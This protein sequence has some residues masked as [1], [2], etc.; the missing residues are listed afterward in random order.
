MYSNLSRREKGKITEF[1]VISRLIKK[2]LDLYVPVIDVGIDCILRTERDGKPTKYFE[3]QIKSTKY[4]VSIRGA[5]KIV[6]YLT[7]KNPKNYFL[8]IAIRKGEEIEHIIYLTKKQITKHMHPQD[9]RSKY[10]DINVKAADRDRLIKT[11][12]LEKLIVKL[13][14]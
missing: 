8:I 5:K 6:Q 11:Q 7:E 4:N 9:V 14:S 3:I 12:T 10:I 1:Q 2:G 13:K